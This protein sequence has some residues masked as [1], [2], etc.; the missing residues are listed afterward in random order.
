MLSFWELR[1]PIASKSPS[2]QDTVSFML[3]AHLCAVTN[4]TEIFLNVA[5][6]CQSNQPTN[7][8]TS[9]FH[10][11][12]EWDQ[13]L[14]CRRCAKEAIEAEGFTKGEGGEGGQPLRK[15]RKIVSK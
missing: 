3:P 5:L 13:S 9:K 10:V 1:R 2:C 4:I 15:L 12:Q 7:Q 8:R 14:Y 11:M 6:S